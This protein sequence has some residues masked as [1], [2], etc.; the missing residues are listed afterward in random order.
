[1]T[2]PSPNA[3]T[4]LPKIIRISTVPSSLN[5]FLRGFLRRLSATYDVLAVSSPGP[6]LTEIREREGVRCA[7]VPME[8]HIAP[9]KD[10][11]SLFRLIS[12]FRRERPTIVH[13]LTPKAGL[14]SMIAARLTGVPVRIHTFTGLV[15]PTS[16]GIKRRLLM[17]TDSL[18]CAAANYINPEG[19]G[20]ARDLTHFGITRK[21]L[22]IIANGNVRGIDLDYYCRDS[23][24]DRTR[25]LRRDDLFTFCFVGRIVGDKGINELAC[26]FSR[27]SRENHSVRLWLIGQF[28]EHLDPVSP[29]TRQILH[30]NNQISCLG[31][32]S[33][34]RPYL[35]AADAL[36]FPSYRE[37]FPNV[38]LE[39]GAMGIPA[40]ATDINGCNEII[41]ESQNGELIPPRDAEALYLKMKQWSGDPAHVQAMAR[42]A[43]RLVAERYEQQQIWSALLSEYSRLIQDIRK[44]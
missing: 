34:V 33:D 19:R 38:V 6:E 23:V 22:H 7:S 44:H 21:P 1:M 18:T 30:D 37:G 39:A 32:Q 20:V 24:A 4:A 36:V 8:R 28:E 16:H 5:T 9:L 14:L 43:R 27:L 26:A 3:G 12:L 29:E 15:F 11:V 41:L 42:N 17:F 31:R 10:L 35:A 2:S 25:S 40:I 13:S